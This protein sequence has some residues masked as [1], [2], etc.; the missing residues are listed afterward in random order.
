MH[1]DRYL[2]HIGF[3]GKARPDRA[4]LATLMQ[5]QLHTV[6]FENLDQQLGIQVSTDVASAFAKVVDRR[7]GGWC[8]ELNALFRWA[9]TEIGF[10][11]LTLAAHVGDN[12]ESRDA[13]ADHMVLRV[14]CEG[15]ALLV[16]VGFGGSMIAPLPFD[17]TDHWQPPY[18][19]AVTEEDDGYWRFSERVADGDR[20]A[21]D[22][23]PVPVGEGYFDEISLA[24]Q[25]DAGSSFRRTLK[26]QRRYRDRHVILRGCTKITIAPDGTD[27]Q[28][29]GSG[30]AL[31]DCLREDFD[32]DVP[33][34]AS[35]WPVVKQRHGELFGV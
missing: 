6:P 25:T 16:D 23:R 22:F 7:R 32:L 10:E 27:Q 21:F 3:T 11:V 35:I 26:A 4:T 30:R 15:I 12:G 31:V 28:V 5:A 20:T 2:N 34:I 1:L 14:D 24:L 29:L 18:T 9:L 33:E 13:P 8:F 19:L 17:Q